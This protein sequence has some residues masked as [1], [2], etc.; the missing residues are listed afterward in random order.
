MAK[1]PKGV[2]KTIRSCSTLNINKV[3]N[4]TETNKSSNVSKTMQ[5]YPMQRGFKM[6]SLNIVSLT[7]KFDGINLTGSDKLLDILAKNETKLDSTI[8]DG[9][10][11]IDGYE[12]V[13]QARSTQV[14]G[15]VST[16]VSPLTTKLEMTLYH[17]I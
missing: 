4:T 8:N 17:P 11:H 1:P 14:A 15:C 9:R 13:R 2:A 7:K 10:V 6:A 16:C 3:N 5:S 12:L